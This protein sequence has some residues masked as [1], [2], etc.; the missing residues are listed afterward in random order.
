MK[1]K[2]KMLFAYFRAF[3]SEEVY[4]TYTMDG[5]YIDDST[6]FTIR[7]KRIK[8]QELILETIDEL[9]KTYQPEFDRHNNYDDDDYWYLDIIIYPFKNILQF[10]S[11]CKI[12]KYDKHSNELDYEILKNNTITSLDTIFNENNLHKI[13]FDFFGRWGDG[14]AYN[15]EYDNRFVRKNNDLFWDVT[16]EIMSNLEDSYWY[17]DM[18]ISGDITLFSNEI[19]VNY[20][21]YYVEYEKTDLNLLINP[22]NVK[23]K[24]E[25]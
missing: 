13:E 7:E 23:E 10:N 18:G 20:K 4:V 8:P 11:E 25:E 17:D 1:N 9:I 2:L 6:Y 22:D 14:E 5:S 12:E 24:N 3:K 19:F 21:K 16:F 15:I